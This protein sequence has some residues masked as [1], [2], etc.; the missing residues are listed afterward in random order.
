[1]TTIKIIS[2]KPIN[3]YELKA[4]LVRIRKRDKELNFRAQKTEEH[5]ATA[6]PLKN[7]DGLFADLSKL[8]V[9]RLRE[10]QIHKVIDLMPTTIKD[11]KVA[12]QGYNVSLSAENMQKI[13]DT[14]AKYLK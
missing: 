10:Q 13:V 4:E 3:A 7:V 5:M 6:A 2:E 12:L 8:D 14:V 1:M 11:L 9:S